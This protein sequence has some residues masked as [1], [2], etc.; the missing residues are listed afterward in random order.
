MN[1]DNINNSAHSID[2]LTHLTV[3]RVKR[4]S[5]KPTF[6]LILNFGLIATVS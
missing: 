2:E 4:K 6:Q 5:R 1:N 3:L